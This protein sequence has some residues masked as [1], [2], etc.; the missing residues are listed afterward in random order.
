MLITTVTQKGQ[1]TIPKEIRDYLGLDTGSKVEFIRKNGKVNLEQIQD[2]SSMKGVVKSKRKFSQK[3]LKE[4]EKA[5]EE[6]AV[7]Q[8]LAKWQK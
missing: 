2:F 6:E 8:Y 7:R 1:V 4:E 3:L 5:A